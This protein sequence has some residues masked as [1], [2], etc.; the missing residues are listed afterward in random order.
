MANKPLEKE[1]HDTQRA[2]PSS[3]V[4]VV[5]NTEDTNAEVD[6][7]DNGALA[8]QAARKDEPAVTPD[9]SQGGLSQRATWA[10]IYI[11]SAAVSLFM[12]LIN[13]GF[14]DN[15]NSPV[16]DE[17]HYA[18]QAFQMLFI[19]GHQEAFPGYGLVV[20]PPLGKTL[21]SIGEKIFGYTPLGWRIMPIIAGVI[22][23]VLLMRMIH[24]I[25]GNAAAV[26]FTAVLAN[27][28]GTQIFMSRI[29]MLDIFTALFV[30]CMAFCIL[31][32]HTTDTSETPWHLRGWLLMSGVF[33]GCAMAVK[34]SGAFYAAYM[35]I[36]LVL[37]VAVKSKS[38]RQTAKALGMG[39]VFYLVIPLTIFMLSWVPWFANENS[40][41]RHIAE[42][43]DI[44]HPLPDWIAAFLPDSVK[45]FMSY[46]IGVAKFHTGLKSG[47]GIESFHPWESKPEDWFLGGRP[48]LF[49]NRYA[50]AD[51]VVF[52]S[53]SGEAKM[54]LFANMAVWFLIIPV[55][56]WATYQIIRN[57]KMEWFIILS[58]FAVG[59]IPWFI[60]YDRQQYFFY[61]VSWSMFI[62]LGVSLM[63]YEL[64][65]MIAANTKISKRN[66]LAVSY[67][68]YGVVAAIVFIAYLPW[69][70]DIPAS[71][72]YHKALTLFDRW[73]EFKGY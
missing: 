56:I 52:G 29:A 66:A 41:Y 64:A 40:V 70:Y 53:G 28:E 23:V 35:G 48:M 50:E 59:I 27:L 69:L 14:T 10:L 55:I 16:F 47:E 67:I 51:T 18:P 1:L 37:I 26:I 60:A 21:L 2:D 31:K 4:E 57:E 15:G 58:G 9:A 6:L 42:A 62:I 13:I 19:P 44:E 24:I 63:L 61:T 11:I 43:G 38:V 20:H 33:A 71:F 25:T 7:T 32:D 36:M 30:T 72:D 49:L 54:V 12:R 45:S 39:L 46:Q 8:D 3:S 5:E 65:G 68:P 22:I 34:M 17:K 73:N